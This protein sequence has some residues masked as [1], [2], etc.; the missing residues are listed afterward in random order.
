MRLWSQKEILEALFANYDKLDDD[1]KAEL[2]LKGFGWLP[3]RKMVEIKATNGLNTQN[4]NQR[5]F[6]SMKRRGLILSLGIS[7]LYGVCGSGS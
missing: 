1:I 6:H 5:R 2:L 7:N 4:Y 3:F